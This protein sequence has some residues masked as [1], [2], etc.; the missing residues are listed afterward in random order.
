MDSALIR[1]K[2]I[3]I[4]LCAAIILGCGGSTGLE[5]E[6]EADWYTQHD[7]VV[8]A[9]QNSKVSHVV[10][11][12][13][14]TVTLLLYWKYKAG[15][16]RPDEIR[17]S[18]PTSV[19][20]P[21]AA[22]PIPANGNLLQNVNLTSL[23]GSGTSTGQLTATVYRNGNPDPNYLIQALTYDVSNSEVLALK[24]FSTDA[25]S[26]SPNNSTKGVR[27]TLN[28]TLS[29][30]QFARFRIKT[31]ESPSQE[32]FVNIRYPD[33]TFIFNPTP[34]SG[35]STQFG[36]RNVEV[37]LL[38]HL[39]VNDTVVN[40]HLIYGPGSNHLSGTYTGTFTHDGKQGTLTVNIQDAEVDG[41]AGVTA[42][43][44]Q[45]VAQ[46]TVT[47]P[48]GNASGQDVIAGMNGNFPQWEL[49]FQPIGNYVGVRLIQFTD[50]QVVM[51]LHLQTPD[52]D[53]VED[54]VLN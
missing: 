40:Q 1:I 49:S 34:L 33:T 7:F 44:R 37:A 35:H 8:S 27:I 38:D 29:P 17:F 54:I 14:Q 10:M 32:I 41:S 51:N 22:I 12:R 5:P 15:E 18:V 42:S 4:G 53:T 26:L 23:A 52:G 45:Y 25:T 24:N 43:S 16:E 30:N 39:D 19:F 6:E 11:Q 21:I 46:I 9:D 31:F 50:T 47:H 48:N 13:D 36:L 28:Q 2:A 3:L 20:Q